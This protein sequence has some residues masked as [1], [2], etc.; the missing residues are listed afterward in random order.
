VASLGKSP[1]D[2]LD[3]Q[4][5]RSRRWRRGPRGSSTQVLEVEDNGSLFRK[6]PRLVGFLGKNK[7]APFCTIWELK[8]V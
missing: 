7:T 6:P 5:V 4:A 3:G 8:L 1:G 2:L